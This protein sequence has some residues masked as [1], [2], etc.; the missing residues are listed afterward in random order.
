MSKCPLNSVQGLQQFDL[1]KYIDGIWKRL[2]E[3]FIYILETISLL[4]SILL[5]WWSFL[6]NKDCHQAEC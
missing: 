1:D 6:K 5:F 4:V 3:I 2:M